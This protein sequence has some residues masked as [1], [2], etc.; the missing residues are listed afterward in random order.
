[1]ESARMT[2]LN[3]NH[4]YIIAPPSTSETIPV[5]DDQTIGTFGCNTDNVPPFLMNQSM[6]KLIPLYEPANHSISQ[7]T[8]VT[9]LSRDNSLKYLT[10]NRI[11]SNENQKNDASKNSFAEKLMKCSQKVLIFQTEVNTSP[12]IN[13]N[14][15]MMK[16]V[17]NGSIRSGDTISNSSLELKVIDEEEFINNN[18]AQMFELN[19]K[20]FTESDRTS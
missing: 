9:S 13:D 20:V 2:T 16:I 11:S 12:K 18:V 4:H 1:M 19:K 8:T 17:S 3:R 15:K 5:K 7:Q 6:A 14:P 10:N